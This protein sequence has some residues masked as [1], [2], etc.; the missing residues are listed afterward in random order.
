MANAMP[1]STAPDRGKD[2][3]RLAFWL[4]AGLASRGVG[5][6][7]VATE[8]ATAPGDDDF[9]GGLLR[10]S[11]ILYPLRVGDWQAVG[12]H[13]FAAQEHGLSV[14][15]AHGRDQDRW[16]DVYFYPAG[17]L[18]AQEFVTAAGQEATLIQQAHALAGHADVDLGPLQAFSFRS[19]D[20]GPFE[21]LALDLAYAADGVAYSSAMT[22]LLDRLYFVKARLSVEQRS[23][24]R[25]AA[26]EQVQAFTANLQPRLTIVN[27]GDTLLWFGQPR[28]DAGD[29]MQLRDSAGD[30][31]EVRLHYRRD[32]AA[33]A[34]ARPEYEAAD[35]G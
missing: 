18:S 3:E 33:C 1:T 19:G 35:V 9:V 14:R 13:L 15:Y 16:I 10:E 28:P 25:R 31:R 22:L 27:S 26:R 2:V 6:A 17:A 23:F 11:R 8:Q 20:G 34:G 5:A 12:E 21:G 4:C 24:S 30:R 32:T 7:P 29:A